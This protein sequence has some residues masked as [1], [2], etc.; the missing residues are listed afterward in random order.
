VNLRRALYPLPGDRRVLPPRPATF[1][2]SAPQLLGAGRVSLYAWVPISGSRDVP[3]APGIRR[4]PP[5][6]GPN[7]R[8]GHTGPGGEDA[9]EK[10]GGC[11]AVE[12]SRKVLPN[13]K[14][15]PS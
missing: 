15:S 4:R 5:S 14:P 3:H 13:N 1:D 11:E 8:Y 7:D 2:P 9:P 10:E 12:P 6:D